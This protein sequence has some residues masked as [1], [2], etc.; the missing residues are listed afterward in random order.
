[1]SSP[2][3]ALQNRLKDL[4]ASLG[5]VHPLI[6]RLRNLTTAIGQGDEAR[7]E[8]STEIHTQLKEVEE[9]VELV[10]VEIEALEPVSE[11]RR[12]GPNNE[13]K[14]AERERVVSLAKRFEADLKRC[15]N[16]VERV[17]LACYSPWTTYAHTLCTTSRTRAEF[18]SAQL[19]AKRNA[20]LAKR[21]E[22]DLLFSRSASASNP[23]QTSEKL[24]QED[25]AVNASS[26]VTS[27]LKRTYQLM[28]AELS[29]SQF[30]Q[31]TLGWSSPLAP[32]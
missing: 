8:L 22:R 11:N 32:T 5:H 15:V 28:Q 9:E 21:K 3:V 18:R 27:A 19:Q 6:T 23:R 24:T 14:E 30:A 10:Q 2:T 26:D 16:A 25:M 12:R 17:N 13:E 1:M 7:L 20:E 4:S 29:K 31:Q